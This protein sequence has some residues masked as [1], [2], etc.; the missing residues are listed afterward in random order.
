MIQWTSETNPGETPGKEYP[1]IPGKKKRKIYGENTKTWPDPV[2]IQNEI[3]APGGFC[4]KLCCKLIKFLGVRSTLK[5]ELSIRTG[6][7]FR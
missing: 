5:I 4:L 6:E 1:K 7:N 3:I 2:E